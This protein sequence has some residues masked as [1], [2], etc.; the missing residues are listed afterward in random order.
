MKKL[1]NLTS[2]QKSI[3]LTEKFYKDSTINN[4]CGTAIISEKLNFKIL[5]E[6][7]NY[8]IKNNESFRIKFVTQ[9][10]ELYQYVEDYEFQKIEIY[11]LNSIEEVSNL[12][13][14]LLHNTYNLEEK[15]YD[16]NIF[17]FPDY[18]GGFLLNIHHIV[19]DAWTLGLTC[20]KIMQA[21]ENILNNQ[22]NIFIPEQSY[23]RYIENENRYLNSQ[24]YLKDKEYWDNIFLNIPNQINLP[25]SKKSLVPSFSC[26]ANRSSFILSKELVNNISEFC[27]KNKI[28][29]FNFFMSVLAIYIF[30]NTNLENFVVGTPI[31]NR[32][33]FNEKQTTGMFINIVPLLININNGL[34]LTEFINK[35]STDLMGL[36][37]HQRY[38]YTEILKNIRKKD[39]S[40]Q[41]LFNILLSYQITKANNESSIP[42]K[43]RWAFNGACADDL[44][45]QIY[46]LDEEKSL[47]ISYDYKVDKF[48]KKDINILHTQLLNIINQILDNP[49]I[50]ISDIEILSEEDK[51]NII[52]KFNKTQQE[53]D[54]TKT[55]TEL[56][57]E[58]VIK[59]P[60]NT[61]VVFENKSIT[62]KELDIESNKIANY[63]VEKFNIKSGDFVSIFLNRSINLISTILGVIKAGATYIA[64]DPEYPKDRIEQMILNSNSK[65]II[66]NNDTYRLALS[67]TNKLINIDNVIFDN[68][69]PLIDVKLSAED[70]LYVIYTSGST[71]TPKGVSIKH[72]NVHNFLLGMRDIID[73]S[74]CN[75]V[76]SVATVCFDMFVFELWCCLLNGLKL[77]LA[78]EDE[79][80]LPYLL[81]KLCKENQVDIFQTTP[82][83]FKLMFDNNTTECFK[84]IKHILIGGEFVPKNMFEKFKE[85][86]NIRIHH[87]YGPTETTVWSTHKEITNLKNISI[88]C[89]ILNTQVY[90]LN[91]KLKICPIGVPGEIYISGDGVG[92][93]YLNNSKINELS[94][95]SNPFIPST[96]MYK[97]GDLGYYSASGEINYLSRVDNQIKIR[98]YRIELDE[99]ENA[100]FQFENVNNCAV[101][102]KEISSNHDVLCAYYIENDKVNVDEL[103]KYLQRKLP[104]YMIPQ[105]FIQMTEFPYTQNGKIDR[106]RLPPPNLTINKNVQTVIRNEYDRKLIDI[107]KLILENDNISINDNL[108][109]LGMDSLT[110]INISVKLFDEFKFE[111]KIS[112]I[113]S[114][115]IIK[116]LSDYISQIKLSNKSKKIKQYEKQDSYS[117]SSA[118]QRI[119]YATASN[120]P[121]TVYNISGGIV[122]DAQPNIKHLAKCINTI[123]NKHDSFKS[124]FVIENNELVQKILDEINFSLIQETVESNDIDA[125]FKEFVQPFDLSVAPLFRA[126][127][128]KLE[129]GKYILI[130]DTHHIICDGTSLNIFIN[131]LCSLYN[132]FTQT[133]LTINYTDYILWEKENIITEDFKENEKYWIEQFEDCLPILNLPTTFPRPALKSYQG[134]TITYKISKKIA[135]N[136]KEFS[137]KHNTT[138]NIVLL[139]ALYLLLNKY[140]H[141]ND[142]IVG[143]PAI[144]RVSKELNN[145][146]GMFVNT[147]PI[148]NKFD[149]DLSLEKFLEH[150][151]RLSSD[152]LSHQDYSL[153]TLIS[154]IHAPRDNSRNYLF[155]I[156]F[157]YQTNR[158]TSVA[159]EDVNA[160]LYI[161]QNNTSKYDISLEVLPINEEF[162]LSF[163]YCTEL[164][165]EKYINT[166]IKHYLNAI[167]QLLINTNKKIK[168]VSI[169]SKKEIQKV[170]FDFNNTESQYDKNKTLANL[171]EEQVEKTPDNIAIVFEEETITYFELNKKANQLARYL[172]KIGLKENSIIGIMLP[173]S[174]EVL[175]CMLAA[176]KAGI[177]YIPI[178]PT[179]PKNRI[180]FM[181][182]NSNAST[183]LTFNTITNN[184]NLA[185]LN[186]TNIIN[187][188]LNTSTIYNGNA[189]NLK[190][191]INPES[192]SYAIYTSGSTGQPKGV[193]LNQK[194]LSNLTNYL[195]DYVEFFKNKYDNLAMLSITTISFDIF[196]FETLISLQKGLKIVLANENEQNTP[197]LLDALIEKHNVKC[198]QTTPSRMNLFLNNSSSMKNLSNLEYVVLAGEALPEAT[199][200]ELLE[201]NK[202][203]TIYNGYGPSETT[204]F[205]TFT[206][207][208]KHKV[209]TIGKPLNNTHIYILDKNQEPVAV[210]HIG[211]VYI[212][213][214]GVALKYINNEKI[215]NERFIENPFIPNTIMY[216]T[217]DLAKYLP[218]GEISYAGRV[219]N[220]VKIRGLRIEL[221]EI[222]NAILEF[223]DIENCIVAVKTDNTDRQYIVA[224][225]ITTNM[226]SFSKLRKHLKDILP[227]YMI[228][229]Y[230]VILD[231]IPYL[232]NGKINKKALPTPKITTDDVESNYIPPKT[233]L[234]IKIVNIFQN[235]LSVSPI[236]INDN[237]FELGG[238]SL[239]AIN[240][241]I[242]LSKITNA[243]TYSDIFL[244]PTV[245]EIVNKI[246]KTKKTKNNN[247]DINEFSKYQN[248]LKNMK[249]KISLS[250]NNNLNNNILLTGA[251]G[252][253][254]SHIL[255]SFIENNT[256]IAYCIVRSKSKLTAKKHFMNALHYYFGT[257]YDNLIDDRIIIVD[258]ELTKK[259]LGLDPII[260][261][262]MF[263]NISCVINSAAKVSHYGDYS[264]FKKINVDSVDMLLKLCKKY[265]KKFYQI[266]TIS[267]SGVD[268]N[269]QIDDN[270]LFDETSLYVNQNLDNVYIRSKFEAEKIVLDYILNDVDCYIIRVGNLMNRF[271]DYKFQPNID[272]N[273]FITR[274]SSFMNLGFLPQYLSNEHL[275]FTPVDLCADGIVKIVNN[276]NATNR[277][278]HLYNQNHVSIKRFVKTL[279]EYKKISFVSNKEFLSILNEAINS[280][281]S[282]KLLSGII[283]DLDNNKK[284]VYRSN[285]KVSNDFT[286]NYLS[287]LNFKWPK[288]NDTY[289]ENFIKYILNML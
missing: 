193:L 80:K 59:T 125:L 187:V 213:G 147:L 96:I 258:S 285:I 184:I 77:V 251:T 128:V 180:E 114:S 223:D 198:I 261:N 195:N 135:Q 92:N 83:R 35:I 102:K 154:K 190:L 157:T 24:K 179:L 241:Q 242:E 214:D 43:T 183:I 259:D 42:Y 44:D 234:E 86:S 25:N 8:V 137:K 6:A 230:F 229:T 90:I 245:E 216:K 74:E 29:T 94:F 19:S 277:I 208:T 247:I 143:T 7:I 60:N 265:K 204:V 14:K 148:R 226:I 10:N 101:S 255:S 163:E 53:Y 47:N 73:F 120:V 267:I 27:A 76:V 136:I 108:F 139:S 45:I 192:P 202:K 194:A 79:Q 61:A 220:Q 186:L 87:M 219:D 168:E 175:I 244:Y 30:K 171:I 264:L 51:F 164:F 146:I 4:I 81:D 191:R 276:S 177:C 278:F 116:D 129:N 253:L 48:S 1:E 225:L 88:G 33:S 237:F 212:A 110:A 103:K 185:D 52:N 62:Y 118:E 284:L 2:P 13:N 46:D 100:I 141:Q 209:I 178:D 98:G 275:E 105:Y 282:D 173:R 160:Q 123:L 104:I 82:S 263:G 262:K 205:S 112:E 196:I 121:S 211:E 218:N 158:L 65:I 269:T 119:Y 151:K 252:F 68:A 111:L 238:D 99:I 34:S 199:K 75:A 12:E 279:E 270:S 15:T 228:P 16:F 200:K 134:N 232:P 113:F 256:G 85:Y 55:I 257:K 26:E 122:F 248:L 95:I 260:L 272:E 107:L 57:K 150:I 189:E 210:N 64:I 49:N 117:L 138:P 222:E 227:Q 156:L 165:D 236:G 233:D 167:E 152:A 250:E 182:K 39:S 40:F 32:T 288:I 174:I 93:G 23:I 89:P 115:P 224:Y 72:K 67:V 176:L 207:V 127:I 155:D 97:T 70:L 17:R 124:Y 69:N 289:L 145:V 169:L 20:R 9:N 203:I 5:E 266:S 56:F 188:K 159:F 3:L 231:K 172:R 239:L 54:K 106:K 162:L 126:K 38:P 217:G 254:G 140:T 201:L 21:Y 63:L 71:G 215:T 91:E 287:K 197:I 109:E 31:L 132:N 28:S 243:V 249:R 281:N 58:Q 246:K 181:L 286:N 274:L 18:T 41:N 131:E 271:S 22:E 133:E 166:F 142:I 149:D 235:L 144:G 273:A 206:D 36:L 221:D 66:T 11:N 268:G 37:R 283:K 84:N 240:L 50:N 280:N 153:D 170:L 78:N 161:P 130:I